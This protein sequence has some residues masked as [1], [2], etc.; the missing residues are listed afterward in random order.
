M[1]L[2]PVLYCLIDCSEIKCERELYYDKMHVAYLSSQPC[3]KADPDNCKN[4]CK[5]NFIKICN[6][7][8]IIFS[9]NSLNVF[10]Q[11]IFY[12]IIFDYITIN[13]YSQLIVNAGKMVTTQI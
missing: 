11:L 9:F 13:L 2:C 5:K 10:F 8:E 1:T 3:C 4:F 7:V 12:T 6:K